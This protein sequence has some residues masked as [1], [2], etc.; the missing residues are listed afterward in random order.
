MFTILEDWLL[1]QGLAEGWARLAA[2]GISFMGMLLVSYIGYFLAR[3]PALN[4]LHRVTTRTSFKA[5][6]HLMDAGFFRRLTWLVPALIIYVLTPA[7]LP[8]Y[9]GAAKF[10]HNLLLIY[11]TI[12][13]FFV[14]DALLNAINN[15]Y[16]DT[17]GARE[18]PI[19]GFLQG[20]KIVMFV[21]C[22]ILIIAAILNKTPFYLLSGLGALTAVLMLIFKDAILGFVAG[23]QLAGNKMVAKGDWISMPQYGADG[24]VV[25]VALTTVKVQNWDKTVTTIPTYALISESF[26]NWRGM[27][28]SGGRRIM[29]SIN[30]DM[31]TIKLCTPEMLERY[32]KIEHI[33]Q[34]ITEKKE[35]VKKYNEEHH[36]DETCRVNGRRLTNVGTFRAYITAYLKNHPEISQEMTFLV[37]QLQPTEHGLPIQIYVF[38]KQTSWVD[39]EGIQADIFDHL[40]AVAPEFD[41]RIFQSPSGADVNEAMHALEQQKTERV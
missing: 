8:N 20:V 29:R 7:V 17:D 14:L 23:I 1:R 35:D 12:I 25:D 16:E 37:R 31:G 21:V 26:Q 30:V 40:L 9:P 15:I 5:D 34:Y 10:I 41:L 27:F 28:E 2:S 3:R 33:K 24:F 38:S 6:D 4:L 18:V 32:A 39:Y 19:K 22:F 36:V 13:A 11:I